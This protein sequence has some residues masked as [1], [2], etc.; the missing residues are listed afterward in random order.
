MAFFRKIVN[1]ILR[2]K[3]SVLS[4]KVGCRDFIFFRYPM[5]DY[6][7]YSFLLSKVEF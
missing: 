6:H 2:V 5:E 1:K 3:L 4:L 7:A